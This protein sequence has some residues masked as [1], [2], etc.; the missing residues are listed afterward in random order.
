MAGD[1]RE[2]DREQRR[3]SDRDAVTPRQHDG[4]SSPQQGSQFLIPLAS[5]ILSILFVRH[6]IFPN[7]N[8]HRIP[9][10]YDRLIEN[11]D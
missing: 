7:D 4:R 2:I 10:F 5:L 1:Q 8:W 9:M 3:D 11:N 6:T